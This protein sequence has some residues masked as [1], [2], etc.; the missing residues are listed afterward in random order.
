LFFQKG[1]GQKSV[2]KIEAEALEAQL[3]A[4]A[5]DGGSGVDGG[6][7]GLSSSRLASVKSSGAAATKYSE[8]RIGGSSSALLAM[9]CCQFHYVTKKAKS[10]VSTSGDGDDN[11]FVEPV[12]PVFHAPSAVCWSE[13]GRL[14][15]LLNDSSITIVSVSEKCCQVVGSV[16]PTHV[17]TP[18]TS[19]SWHAGMLVVCTPCGLTAVL[20]S[21]SGLELVQLAS[22]NKVS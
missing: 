2:S 8:E 7:V 19:L 21:S 13:N 17:L 6:S 22:S 3:D 4:A 1:G 5:A 12:G 14:C 20:A 9:Q 15:A 16:Q 18:V 10:A 11:Y